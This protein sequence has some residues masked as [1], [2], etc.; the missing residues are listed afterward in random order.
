MKLSCADV[1]IQAVQLLQAIPSS[2]SS[3]L[4]IIFNES[5]RTHAKSKREYKCKCKRKRQHKRRCKRKRECKLLC[6]NV[7]ATIARHIHSDSILVLVSVGTVEADR[8][9]AFNNFLAS[10]DYFQCNKEQLCCTTLYYSNPRLSNLENF[11]TVY[12]YVS[13]IIIMKLISTKR[14]IHAWFHNQD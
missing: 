3:L 6:K 8:T 13:C 2:S 7:L 5:W 1:H 9:I 12:S 14:V 10:L 4:D 11:P